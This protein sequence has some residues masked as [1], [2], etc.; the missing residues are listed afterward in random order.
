MAEVNARSNPKTERC[1]V[2]VTMTVLETCDDS[3]VSYGS[4]IH[5]LS[6]TL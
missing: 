6:A 5:A 2:G 3:G 1:D 4:F